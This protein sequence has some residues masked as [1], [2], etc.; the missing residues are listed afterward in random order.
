MKKKPKINVSVG[1]NDIIRAPREALVSCN[2]L[3][4]VIEKIKQDKIPKVEI[5]VKSRGFI[6][7][8]FEQKIRQNGIKQMKAKKYMTKV[9]SKGCTVSI[10]RLVS[11]TGEPMIKAAITADIC[12]SKK[13]R[14]ADV[15]FIGTLR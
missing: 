9:A 8:I 6:I 2:P 15:F 5:A 1:I 11:I 13:D 3:L 12:A 7:V 14:S 10:A 4:K